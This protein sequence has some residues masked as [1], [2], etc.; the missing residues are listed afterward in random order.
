MT[1]PPLILA[2]ESPRRVELLRQIVPEFGVVASNAHELHD[3]SLGVRRLCEINAERKALLVAE[4]YPGHL[5]L[6]A[7]TLVWLDGEPLAKPADLSEART[8]LARLSGRVHEVVTGVCLVRRQASRLQVF[9]ETTR[10]RFREISE[11]TIGDYLRRVHT[12]DKAGGYAVQEHGDLIVEQIEGS[13]TNVIGLPLEALRRALEGWRAAN[14]E[15]PPPG[16][17]ERH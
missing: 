9:S 5:I 15:M 12:L 4:R 3:R 11:A 10:V 13:L 1:L 2:S 6:G 7:D 14:G 16:A 8:M 17:A